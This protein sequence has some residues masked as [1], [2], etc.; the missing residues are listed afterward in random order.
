MKA[1][2][3][4]NNLAINDIIKKL[5]QHEGKFYVGIIKEILQER[6]II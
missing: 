6:A 5:E 3:I 2:L 4:Q 1:R